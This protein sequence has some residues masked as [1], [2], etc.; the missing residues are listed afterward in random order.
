MTKGALFASS[1]SLSTN[2]YWRNRCRVDQLSD[3]RPITVT[4]RL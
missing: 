1:I 3:L 2:M 4:S